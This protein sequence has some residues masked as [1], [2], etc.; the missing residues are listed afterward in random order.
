MIVKHYSL[1]FLLFLACSVFVAA[2]KDNRL[3]EMRIYTAE[4]GR[5]NDLHKRFREHTT[6]LFV[7]HGMTNVG[8]WVPLDNPDEKLYYV[9]SYPNL[10][11]H[12]A[13]WEAFR[14]DTAWIGAKNRSE[15]NGKLVS[16]VESIYL[17]TTDYSP[18]DLKS[19]GNRIWELRIYTTNEGMLSHLNN[20]FKNH[21]MK[22]FKN[23]GMRNIIYWTPTEEKQGA[24]NMLY[25]FLTHPSADAA[26][27]AFRTFVEDP[28]WKE[29]AA[30]SEKVAGGKIIAKLESIYLFPTDYS[31]I[32]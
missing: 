14:A 7:K 13:A 12:D 18:L 28:K 24:K 22:L 23:H 16:K 19:D 30:N 11:A 4:K 25:Y 2:Q 3:Y 10:A 26:K 9:L 6:K 15:A 8:Y 21:T 5:L 20:R 31:P 29:V 32:K 1:I 27:E 17:K